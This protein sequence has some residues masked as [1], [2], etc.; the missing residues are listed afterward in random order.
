MQ[1]TP[2]YTDPL[3]VGFLISDLRTNSHA[4]S[5]AAR[6]QIK[7]TSEA[8]IHHLF[9]ELT[10]YVTSITTISNYVQPVGQQLRN[11]ATQI[12]ERE[13]VLALALEEVVKRN[14][15]LPPGTPGLTPANWPTTTG[16]AQSVI[17]PQDYPC[18]ARLCGPTINRV[19][20]PNDAC[21]SCLQWVE[22]QKNSTPS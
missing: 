19:W 13:T 11:L 14:L 22:G 18:R 15:P 6:R 8:T 2:P 17:Q 5:T 4:Y 12:H 3:T 21:D 10:N 7:S 9:E 20:G 1:T 16:S